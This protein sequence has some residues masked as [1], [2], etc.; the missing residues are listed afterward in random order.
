MFWLQVNSA[1]GIVAFQCGGHVPH[2]VQ[3]YIVHGEYL[4]ADTCF[5]N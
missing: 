5:A 4:S 3:I 2:K 1:T